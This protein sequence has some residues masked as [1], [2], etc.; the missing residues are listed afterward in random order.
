MSIRTLLCHIALVL[1]A[2]PA[3][4][5]AA[6]ASYEAAPDRSAW[7]SQHDG[8]ACHLSHQVP[9][10]G[11]VTF[12][13]EPS[14]RSLLTIAPVR[15]FGSEVK[16][17]LAVRGTRWQ[18][19][20]EQELAL[21][22]LYPA[23]P[24]LRIDGAYV[25]HLLTALEQGRTAVIRFVGGFDGEHELALS[26]VGFRHGWADY[27]SCAVAIAATASEADDGF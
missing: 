7:L 9:L 19:L 15:P 2:L 3:P 16:L 25:E 27:L 12:S 18:P 8:A 6:P 26:P 1:G 17:V 10:F 4:G 5:G 20:P 14:G 23:S 11:S 22:Y 21:L 24:L 13:R